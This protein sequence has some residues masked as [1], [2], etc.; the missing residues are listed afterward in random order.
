MNMDSKITN[1]MLA[2]I[3]ALGVLCTHRL[4]LADDPQ[5]MEKCYGIAK[6][7]A[8]DCEANSPS[9][10]KS[11]LDADPSYWI[12]LPKGTC[13]KIVGG[14]TSMGTDTNPVQSMPSAPATA[15][16]AP[17]PGSASAP[18]TAPTPPPSSSTGMGSMPGTVKQ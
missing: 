7:G 8:N 11:M 4:A 10:G 17:A 6:A 15:T 16:T 9:C 3:V 5:T 18:S 1:I 13:D 2:G 12:Y 14:M